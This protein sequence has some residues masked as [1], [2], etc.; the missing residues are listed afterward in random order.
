MYMYSV[1]ITSHY[2]QGSQTARDVSATS[3]KLLPASVWISKTM[4]VTENV[5]LLTARTKVQ[6]ATQT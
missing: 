1:H 3:T 4:L 2:L 6:S 5:L